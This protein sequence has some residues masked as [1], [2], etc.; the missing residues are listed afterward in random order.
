[1]LPSMIV[2]L[3]SNNPDWVFFALSFCITG[4]VGTALFLA[5]RQGRQSL[6]TR[7]A[8]VLTTLSWVFLTIFGALPFYLSGT[9]PD[10]VDAFF[11][12]MSGLTTT[13]A[14]ILT[15]LDNAPPGILFWRSTLQWLGGLGIIVMAVA[16]LPMLQIGGMQV[17]RAE[18]FDTAEKILPRATQI[19]SS[20]I[21][22]FSFFT[23]LCAA[24]YMVSG[25]S[26]AD[27]INH[28]MTTVATGGFS[29]R[30]A[31]FGAF[32]NPAAEW[33]GIIFMLVGSLPFL[34]YIQFV[35]GKRHSL[36]MDSQVRAFFGFLAFLIIVAVMISRFADASLGNIEVRTVVFNTVSI[37]TGTGYA[38]TDYNAWGASA[39]AFFFCIMFIGGC[40]GSTSCGIKIFRFQLLFREIK[41]HTQEVFYP[42][43]VF[44]LRYNGRK[45]DRSVARSVISFFILYI[46]SFAV[47]AV[48]LRLTGLDFVT[49]ISGAGS[50]IS[51]VGPGLGPIIGPAGNYAEIN[52]AAKWLLSFGMLLGRLELFAILVVLLPQFWLD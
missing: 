12:A 43:G 19:S 50:A 41:R 15:D 11:E 14:T 27:S 31:S 32:D 47:L 30:D 7:Q 10:Y 5:T 26:A 20:L 9:T 49:A 28:A 25:L 1:M 33:V 6:S 52:E 16:V 2:D 44:V 48:L 35:Q 37:L 34:A 21:G 17:F 8:M 13:G 45:L 18:A 24:A 42:N 29:T 46:I 22:V 36:V 4:F 40:A 51:N 39:I 38:S 3:L 23:A